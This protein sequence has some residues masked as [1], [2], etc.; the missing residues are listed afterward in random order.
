MDAA[1]TNGAPALGFGFSFADLAEREALV[2]L[3]HLFLDRLNAEDQDLQVRLLA[4]RADPG[5]LNAKQEGELIVALGP[6]LQMLI[7]SLFGIEPELRAIS[8]HTEQL[9]PIHVCKRHFVQ[10]QAVKKFPDPSG[11]DAAALSAALEERLGSDLTERGFAIG[12]ADWEKQGDAAALDLAM[13][14]AAW[15]TLT[16]AGHDA[17]PGNTLFRVPHKLDFQHL[18]PTETIERNGVRMLRLPPGRWRHRD[19]FGLTDPGMNDQQAL[20]QMNYCIWCHE[21]SKDSC[22]KGLRDRKTGA[23]Q[24]SVFGVTLAG[25]PLDEKISEM[26]QQRAHGC[27]IGA[28]ATIAIDNPMMAA[29]GH[30]ICND[31]MKACIYQ[32]QDPVDIPQAETAILRDVLALPWG[33]EIYS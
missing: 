29:T 13:R 16:E 30:R 6:H 5:S 27:L 26:H 24:K 28:F 8:G 12:V 10:R 19:G 22:S 11:F 15:A 18:V 20:D 14:Y 23:F 2:R 9:D 21:Q 25:C 4:A 1:T 3:D 31:C 33:F 32:K 17:H 7:G